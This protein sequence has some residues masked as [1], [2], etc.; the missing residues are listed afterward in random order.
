MKTRCKFTFIGEATLTLAAA[1]R[2]AHER[3]TD[4]PQ[5]PPQEVVMAGEGVSHQHLGGGA[6]VQQAVVGGLEEALVGVE[7]RFEQLVEELA[8]DSAAVDARLVQAVS[9]E[10]VDADPLLQI[11]FWNQ[12]RP[13]FIFF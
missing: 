13:V 2:D 12:R 5:E 3:D 9:V 8:E 1:Q 11:R 6:G 7:A 10:Q 4:L